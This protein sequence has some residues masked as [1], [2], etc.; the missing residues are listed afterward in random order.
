MYQHYESRASLGRK[1][2]FLR[3]A[4]ALVFLAALGFAGGV[5]YLLFFLVPFEQWLV[6]SGVSQGTIDVVLDATILGWVLIGFLLTLL[7][8]RLFLRRGRGLLG[9]VGVA[10]ASVAAAG[11]V[12]FVMLDDDLMAAAGQLGQQSAQEDQRL[13]FGSYPDAE[14]LAELEDEGY[15]GVI[16]LLSPKVPF[17][18]V[19]LEQEEDNGE[20]AGIRV[21]SRPMLPWIT[22]NEASLESIKALAAQKDKQFYIHCY[23]G[24][25]RVDVVRQEL[26]AEAP[27]PTER[28]VDLPYRFERGRVIAYE[29]ERIILGPYP[30]EEEWFEYVLRRD[31]DEVV[32]TLDPDNPDD[33]PWIEEERKIAEEN[34]LK[35]TLMPLD[36]LSPDPATAQEVVRH[37]RDAEGKVFVHDFLDAKRFEAL[38]RGLGQQD[39][40]DTD[41]AD[42]PDAGPA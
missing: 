3:L 38:K 27:D 37:V 9:A 11:V 17:E 15:D 39:P 28:E 34:G 12:F 2:F 10:V 30:T 13:L 32:S 25:H 21:Y 23:L 42:V 20:D 40:G 7:Y 1:A 33:A 35:F 6:D 41:A 29:G 22:G 5:L 16:S 24:K 26:D 18:R 8:A 19:L 14:R 36:P 4:L 31:V